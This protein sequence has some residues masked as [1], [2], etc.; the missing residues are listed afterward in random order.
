MSSDRAASV[1]LCMIVRNEAHQLADCLSPIARLF[2][3]IVIVDTGSQ[4]ATCQIAQQFTNNVYHFAWR[5]DFA[6][7]RNESLRHA[8]GDWMFWLDAD[9]RISP[10]NREKLATLLA[11]LGNQDAAYFMD[12]L[13]RAVDPMDIERVVTHSRLFR[14]HAEIRWHRRVH[15]QLGPW[16]AHFRLLHTGAQIEHLGYCERSVVE[17]KQRRNLRL[18]QMEFAV[19]ADDPEVLLELAILHT[20]RRE[21]PQARQWFNRLLQIGPAAYLD[22]QRVLTSL[23]DLAAQEGDFGQVVAITSRGRSLYRHDDYFAYLQ[24][25]ALYQLGRYPAARAILAELCQR[26]PTAFSFRV[27]SPANIRERLAPLGLGEI[28]RVEGR[29]R[30]AEGVLRTV[31]DAFP[32]DPAAWQFLARVYVD[33][34]DG[35]QFDWAW[36]Q[37]AGLPGGAFYA[38]M[39]NARWHLAQDDNAAAQ[40][41]IDRLLGESPSMP[42]LHLMRAECLARTQASQVDQLRAFRDVLRLKPGQPRASSMV[43]RLEASVAH[44]S[45]AFVHCSVADQPM[46]VDAM[47]V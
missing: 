21:T 8:H 4:D 44:E 17:R 15:E 41:I 13:C 40:Q 27:G 2:D 36:R 1:S 22:S 28:L 19:N 25:E 35:Q 6:A 38:Q 24:A 45:A 10:D 33:L 39:L 47:P 29:L 14:R 11:Q 16:P 43:K 18:L 9:D 46:P 31:T 5:D 7:A 42:L 20:R 3:E 23:A 26:R 37:L 32:H 30:E 34:G 12:T